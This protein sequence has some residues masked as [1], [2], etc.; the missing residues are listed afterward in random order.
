MSG[1]FHEVRFPLPVALGAGGGPEWRTE[2]VALGS[3][4]E[5][6]NSPWRASRRRYDAG[7]GLRTLDDLHEAIAF[8]EARRGRLHGFRWRDPVD[9][10]TAPPSRAPTATD[11]ALGV[12][13]GAR[14]R[15][16]LVKTYASGGARTERRIRKPVAGSAL[17]A[18]G[19]AA[20]AP[21]A[22]ALDALDG[23]IVLAAAPPPGAAVTAGFCFDVPV[24][25]DVDRLEINMSAFAAGEV[26]SI[27]VVEIKLR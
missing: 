4:H 23:A 5:E 22:F 10:Q 7:L 9:F 17:V 12:G 8:F 2:I 26:P 6:R 19:G 16:E 20:L 1:A 18:I 25:F 14:T 27:P 21:A 3:G 15:F 11:Q 24:R 13:D